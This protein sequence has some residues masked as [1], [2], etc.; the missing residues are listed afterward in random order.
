[1]RALQT[2]FLIL[3]LTAALTALG[4]RTLWPVEAQASVTE[5]PATEYD[6]ASESATRT[7][8]WRQLLPAMVTAKRAPRLDPRAVRAFAFETETGSAQE[9]LAFFRLQAPVNFRATVQEGGIRLS[10]SPHPENPVEGRSF[11]ITR[12]AGEGSAEELVETTS[13]EFL[14]RVDCEGLTYHYRLRAVFPRQV[15]AGTEVARESPWAA[16]STELPRTAEWHLTGLAGPER[17]EFVLRR[18]GRPDLGPFAAQAGEE[19]GN[20]GW[21]IEALSIRETEVRVQ[22][23]T[24]RFDALG[25]RVI[26]DGRPA[27]RVREA[28]ANRLLANLRLT[29]PCGTSQSMDLLLPEGTRRPA[30]D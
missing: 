5:T 22:T 4:A 19:I 30:G 25:R 27:D 28:K 26:I 12:W 17:P 10:W 14:D 6:S 29:D 11:R 8:N 24:P 16:A 15:V 2:L 18:P 1:M 20:T 21:F 9:G 23:R 3:A 7:T 13:L